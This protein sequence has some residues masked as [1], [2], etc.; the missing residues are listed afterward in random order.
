MARWLDGY[1]LGVPDTWDT[2]DTWTYSPRGEDPTFYNL[3]LHF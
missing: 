1:S 3:S 2:W